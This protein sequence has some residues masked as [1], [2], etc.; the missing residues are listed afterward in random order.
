MAARTMAVAQFKRRLANLEAFG[1]NRLDKNLK[2]VLNNLHESQH[3]LCDRKIL[4]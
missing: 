3:F 2:K 1:R 4:F